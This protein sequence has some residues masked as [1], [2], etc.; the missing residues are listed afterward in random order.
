MAKDTAGM[1]VPSVSW[2]NSEYFCANSKIQYRSILLL[3]KTSIFMCFWSY[4][5]IRAEHELEAFVNTEY[6]SMHV[7]KGI[8]VASRDTNR[9]F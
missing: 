4:K 9:R 3:K 5:Q 7:P 8:P 1:L 2:R 6:M